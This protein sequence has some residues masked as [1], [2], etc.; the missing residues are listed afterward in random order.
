MAPGNCHKG[1]IWEIRGVVME[2]PFEGILGNSRELQVINHL[3]SLPNL[4]FT[5]WE[6]SNLMNISTHTTDRIIKN[7]LEWDILLPPTKKGNT[8]FYQINKNSVIVKA[9]YYLNDGIIDIM[10]S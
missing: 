4:N 7:F 3:L 8:N 6:L 2:K 10:E 1:F 5:I 9:M